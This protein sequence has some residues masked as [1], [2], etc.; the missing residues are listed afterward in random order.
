VKRPASVATALAA[1]LGAF[2]AALLPCASATAQGP[3]GRIEIRRGDEVVYS[4]PEPEGAVRVLF[5]GNSLTYFNEVP[6]LTQRVV[7]SRRPEP[8]VVTRFSGR[9]GM[10][11]EEHWR[12]GEVQ[13]LLR[14]SHWDWVVLQ[15]QS[16]RPVGEP[17]KHEQYLRLFIDEGRRHGARP[18]IFETWPG[19]R[20]QER[21]AYRR[22][23]RELEVPVAPIGT[24]WEAATRAGIPLYR[25]VIHSNLAGAYL[26]AC[27]L[28]ATLFDVDPRG[29][30]HDF[31]FGAT[32]NDVPRSRQS[33]AEE[34]LTEE[35]ARRLQETA[36]QATHGGDG[37]NPA[38]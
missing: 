2:F 5:V 31:P 38:D 32:S 30:V 33:L 36:W 23:G 25:D 22:L 16:H 13:R 3:P 24:A 26:T 7:E 17:E 14:T 9:S 11:L 1:C 12:T 34:T 20:E 19:K 28:A 8:P 4:R 35:T 27:V 21:Q 6:W 15:E 10:S 37:A 29:A 18:V